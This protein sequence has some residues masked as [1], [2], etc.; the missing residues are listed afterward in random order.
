MATRNT[1]ILIMP[2]SAAP[3]QY[4]AHRCVATL[5]GK[6]C[7][8]IPL[9][10]PYFWCRSY[11]REQ[12]LGLIET[13]LSIDFQPKCWNKKSSINE[14]P[15]TGKRI[16]GENQVGMCLTRLS[17]LAS[18]QQNTSTFTAVSY[19]S[20][21]WDRNATTAA[22][23]PSVLCNTNGRRRRSEETTMK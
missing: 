3:C 2:S 10:M 14:M 6:I 18:M 19:C 11:T 13:T 1:F 21:S 12:V 17:L 7:Q 8:Q 16:I 15:P 4:N 23:V 9:H 20:R 5:K 22:A